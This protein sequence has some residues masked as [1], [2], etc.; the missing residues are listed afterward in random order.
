MNVDTAHESRWKIAEVVFGIPFLASIALQFIIPVA[1]SPGILRQAFI[2]VGI[3]LI[4]IGIGIIVLA[5]REF[6]QHGQPTDP[7]H[8]T[9][10]VIKTGVFAL[11][12]NPLYLGSSIVLLGIALM[13]N[14]LWAIVTLLLSMIICHYVLIMPEERYLA[15]KFGNEYEEYVASVNRWLGRK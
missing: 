7:G 3:T 13:L 10:K 5:R 12:R 14:T 4:I 2:V 8:P 9:S 15:T 1:L 6:A 11:S